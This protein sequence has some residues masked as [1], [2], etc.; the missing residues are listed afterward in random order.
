MDDQRI[1]ALERRLQAVE[2]RLS[3]YN[4]ISAYGPAVDSC[5]IENN[6]ELWAED[7]VYEVGG[8]GE[9]VGHPGLREMI[10]GPF[11]Q[12]VTSGGSG[13]VLSLPHVHLAGDRAVA[14]NYAKLFEHRDGAF[15]LRRLVVSRWE[16]ERR[17]G[18]WKIKRRTNLLLDGSPDSKA[19]LAR[20]P[21]GF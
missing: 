5:S 17:D 21:E 2:D 4:L 8:L 18:V 12:E 13:H 14:T 19:L 16:L 7:S 6:A 1:E 15:T 3:I 9:Y 10:E 11:H 20:T